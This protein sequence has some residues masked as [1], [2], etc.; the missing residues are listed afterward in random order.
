MFTYF[1]VDRLAKEKESY[2]KEALKQQAKVD[3]M[4]ADG[5]DSYEIKKMVGTNSGSIHVVIIAWPLS[6]GTDVCAMCV[7]VVSVIVTTNM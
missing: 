2:E 5:K 3:Q 7:C 1:F 6:S 4:K